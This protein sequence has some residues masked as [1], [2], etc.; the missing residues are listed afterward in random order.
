VTQSSHRPSF[1]TD[2]PY[3][4]LTIFTW[5]FAQRYFIYVPAVTVEP[6]AFTRALRSTLVIVDEDVVL[7]ARTRCAW[8]AVDMRFP[9]VLELP[10]RNSDTPL[11]RLLRIW[12]VI[13]LDWHRCYL[14]T[15][16]FYV[17]D[18]R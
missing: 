10:S 8:C 16:S 6:E 3:T 18:L 11:T 17:L 9:P 13:S 1:V 15:R 7:L 14:S 4:N 2:L 5:R 12:S